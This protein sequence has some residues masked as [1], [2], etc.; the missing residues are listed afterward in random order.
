MK[1]TIFIK[2]ALICIGSIITM[3]GIVAASVSNL[4]TGLFLTFG[5]GMF[6][7]AFGLLFHRIPKWA[8]LALFICLCA[9]AVSATSVF[10][11]GA[12]DSATYKEDAVI[13]LGAGLRGDRPSL[14]LKNR[15]DRA[16][17]YYE[18]NPDCLI[19]VTGGQGAGEDITEALAMER[20]LVNAGIPLKN[21]IKEELSTSTYENFRN[22]KDLLDSRLGEDY[23]ITLITNDFH[24]LRAT[25]IAQKAG[26]DSP[27]HLN[28]PTPVYTALPSVLRECLAILKFIFLG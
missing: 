22:A 1:K 13:V 8:R 11:I 16:V 10:A 21:I 27:T 18:K 25:A 15:L 17:D 14:T 26:F 23:S 2:V 7:V 20:Y 3:N 28:S 9:I 19:V 4:N 12:F 5:L 24:I 6:L